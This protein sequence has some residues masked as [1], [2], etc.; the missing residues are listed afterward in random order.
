MGH[1]IS[2]YSLGRYA[3]VVT[4][5]KAVYA[6][7]NAQP[8]GG[9]GTV[10]MLIGPN[11]PIILE[12]GLCSTYMEHVYDFY[13]PN[14][15]SEYPTVDGKLSV[16]RYAKALDKCYEGFCRKAESF[17]NLKVVMYKIEGSKGVLQLHSAYYEPP[18]FVCTALKD[19]M[20]F[21]LK[22]LDAML[23]HTPYCK[24]VQKSLG[25]LSFNDFIRD[26]NPDMN[27][28]YRGLEAYRNLKLE[29]T[30]FNKEV[31]KAFVDHSKSIFEKK[32]KPSLLTAKE[33]GN[34]YTPSLYACL[35]SFIAS[36]KIEDLKAIRV[37]MFSYGS[38]LAATLFSL[39]FTDDIMKGSQLRYLHDSLQN[40]KSRLTNRRKVSPE[41]FTEIL[42]LRN[43]THHQAPYTP[44]GKVEDLFPKTWYLEHVDEKQRRTYLQT[45]ESPSIKCNGCFPKII[46]ICF[47]VMQILD[48]SIWS[49]TK[50]SFINYIHSFI[51][52]SSFRSQTTKTS[53]IFTK[54]SQD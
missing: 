29:D 27:N 18:L 31:E 21:T 49:L 5:D 52:I 47:P 44:V 30:Y 6:E 54:F 53:V 41:K 19:K 32:T 14:L 12:R 36:Q 34:M 50:L 28:E 45:K 22:D 7:G 39:R 1:I 37:G 51:Y 13:K 15:M 25:R 8:T 26:P 42:K 20:G 11:A 17:I 2:V 43:A 9:A 4:G 48:H 35:V 23:F 10:A 24:L 38:G 3:L 33:V 40:I 46:N 16:Q